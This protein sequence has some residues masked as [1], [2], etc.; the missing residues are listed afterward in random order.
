MVMQLSGG[1]TEGRKSGSG[2]VLSLVRRKQH[3]HQL[4]WAEYIIA[5]TQFFLNG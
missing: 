5:Y 2:Y 1:Q 3:F 4:P